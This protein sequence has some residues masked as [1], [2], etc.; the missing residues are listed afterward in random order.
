MT[1]QNPPDPDALARPAPL[2]P[3]LRR[4]RWLREIR[5][6]FE[7]SGA[8]A[9]FGAHSAKTLFHIAEW[10]LILSAVR[11]INMH[12]GSSMLSVFELILLVALF[13]YIAC[14]T[15][16]LQM[17][18]FRVMD[19]KW[20][21]AMNIAISAVFGIVVIVSTQMIFLAFMTMSPSAGQ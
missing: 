21:I 6:S 19:K 13:V 3:L 18:L 1:T 8:W 16:K 15:W 10:S 4:H 7:R 14:E 11:A 9:E 12:V 20:K 17:T 5:G 2:E